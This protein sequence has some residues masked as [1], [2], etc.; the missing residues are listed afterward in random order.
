MELFERDI[1]HYLVSSIYYSIDTYT[2][3]GGYN[4]QSS[5]VLDGH[6]IK[7]R[8]FKYNG[9]EE[10]IIHAGR[11]PWKRPCFILKIIPGGEAILMSLE[12]GTD[13]F[14]DSYDNSKYL[15]KAAYMLAKQKGCSKLSLTDNSFIVCEGKKISLANLSFLTTGRTWYES[16]LPFRPVNY[17]GDID[18]WREKVKTNS[19]Q[20]IETYLHNKGFPYKFSITGVDTAASGSAIKVFVTLKQLKNK[21]SCDIFANYMFQILQASGIFSLRE[22]DWIL[23]I[24]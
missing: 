7:Y 15:V 22:I 6:T 17:A 9:E 13:C 4:K 21:K 18:N 3:F 23:D 1:K 24:K 8:E 16:I 12:R 14:I 10:L 20:Q 2:Q 19:W 11:E 5:I